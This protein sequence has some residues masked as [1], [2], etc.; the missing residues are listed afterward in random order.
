MQKCNESVLHFT[1][2]NPPPQ[3]VEVVVPHDRRSHKYVFQY[4]ACI[5]LYFFNTMFMQI[6]I[7]LPANPTSPQEQAMPEE[8]SRVTDMLATAP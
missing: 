2:E 7:A 1:A 4:R 5:T 8:V 3:A 6:H